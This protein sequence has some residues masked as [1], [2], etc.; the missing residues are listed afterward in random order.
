LLKAEDF[1]TNFLNKQS[2][3]D[4]EFR[5]ETAL[6]HSKLGD[7]DR[8][9]G[10]SKDAVDQYQ[11]AVAG[12]EPLLRGDRRDAA[13]MQRLGYA[14]NW[15][16]VTL[17]DWAEETHDA[18]NLQARA[19]DEL[20]QALSLQQQL[21]DQSPGNA[22]YQQ[23]LARTYDN[24]GILRSDENDAAGAEK[25]FRE[26]IRLLEPLSGLQTAEN[27]SPPSHDLVLAYNNL[28]AL[29]SRENAL[30]PAQDFA[31]RA[32]QLQQSLVNAYPDNWGYREEL[33]LFRNN[34]SF[35]ALQAGDRQTAR[36][37]NDAALDS[38]ERLATPPPFLERQRA[39]A[40]MLYLYFDPKGHPEFHVLYGAL[41]DQ[42]ATLAQSY[43]S[44]GNSAA[45]R[46][47]LQ[48]LAHI[49]PDLVEPDR[50]RLSKS[51]AN[52]QRALEREA[53]QK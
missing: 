12:F 7:I 34:L 24:R 33:E 43:L 42:Y 39:E 26:A 51:Y 16:G 3:N 36:Q 28:S 31:Q 50:T 46:L 11:S 13:Y 52:L 17:T 19:R 4:P 44:A 27:E 40:H 8:L 21:V 48:S 49:L 41:G 20:N 10:R 37:E 25:D 22:E 53:A 32:V 45:A 23:E 9:M 47:A 6:V 30:Q 15:L 18:P 14:E 29:L 2:Q 5:A 38:I 35:L 1:Y